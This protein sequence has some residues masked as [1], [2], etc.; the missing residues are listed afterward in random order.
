VVCR[1]V[2]GAGAVERE[3]RPGEGHG[4]AYG[5]QAIREHVCPGAVPGG[6]HLSSVGVPPAGVEPVAARVFTRH[7]RVVHYAGATSPA[8]VLTAV[9][10][11]VTLPLGIYGIGAGYSQGREYAELPWAVDIMIVILFAL[12][13]IN[14]LMK[15]I[16]FIVIWRIMHI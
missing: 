8:A 1:A 15:F 16:L 9:L 3:A 11:N 7:G 4:V 2:A 13:V 14:I 5:V 12:V 6:A 10:W